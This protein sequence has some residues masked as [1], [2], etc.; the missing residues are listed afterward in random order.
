MRQDIEQVVFQALDQAARDY[1][2]S[3]GRFIPFAKNRIHNALES[4]RKTLRHV[5]AGQNQRLQK[6][7]PHAPIDISAF[8]RGLLVDLGEYHSQK[9]A[10]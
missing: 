2:H 3:C 9:L 5:P 4:Y 10:Q 7:G 6:R 1:T 8:R